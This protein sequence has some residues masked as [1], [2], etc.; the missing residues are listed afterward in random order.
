MYQQLTLEKRYTLY[1]LR[2]EGYTLRSIAER[3]EVHVSTISRELKRNLSGSGYR[4]LAAHR[5]AME[6][7]RLPRKPIKLTPK[8]RHLV[9]SLLMKHWSP[10]QVAGKLRLDGTLEIS[11]ETIYKYIRANK[12]AG[13]KLHTFLRRK[14][15]YR[16]RYGSIS[17]YAL[18]NKKSID[19]RPEI[20]DR[21]CRIGDWEVDTI[22]GAGNK[23]AVLVTLVERYSK[24]TLIGKVDSK[25]S[26]P[27]SHKIISLLARHKEKV[28]TI[29]AD[30]GTE[31]SGHVEVARRTG[32]EF[33]FAHPYCSWE[34]G[35]NENTNGLIR[36]YI[37]KGSSLN[38]VSKDR[39]RHIMDHINNR[40]RKTLGY[41]TPKEVFFDS[42]VAL[43]D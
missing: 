10:E 35:L 18:D 12:E 26:Y 23:G 13:G 29:T 1:V 4:P 28:L 36:Q 38:G 2:Q 25:E 42:G 39:I 43:Q 3:L 15:K 11:H 31:F 34:R 33:Y 17:R 22:V 16:R 7:R 21:K 27:T 5:R 37:P 30:N 8:A 19:D 24:Y 6:R 41:R 20:V 14:K 9:C 32:S 40:P